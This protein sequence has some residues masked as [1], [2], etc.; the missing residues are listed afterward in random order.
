MGNKA[1]RTGIYVLVA[2]GFLL[3][4]IGSEAVPRSHQTAVS[5]S[6]NAPQSGQSSNTTQATPDADGVYHVGH[7]VRPPR[8]V[9]S[10]DP[11][12]T[13]LA[14][15]K[16]I[17][18]ICVVELVVDTEGKPQNVRVVRSIGTDL[19]SIGK[20]LDPK[21]QKAAEGLDQNA[22]NAVSRYQFIPAEYQGMPVPVRV[23]VE[24]NFKLF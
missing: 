19:K 16:K 23:N 9:S 15:K 11:Q 8:I 10:V 21:L 2:V 6:R 14:R 13:D 4:S 22:V 5:G 24:V 18:G 20:D 12:Y 3:L 7:G 1:C 17:S